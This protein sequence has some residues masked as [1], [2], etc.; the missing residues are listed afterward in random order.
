MWSDTAPVGRNVTRAWLCRGGGGAEIAEVGRPAVRDPRCGE[1]DEEHGL[2]RLRRVLE[3]HADL[4]ERAVAL[5]E[6]ARRTGGDDVLPDRLAALRARD[7]VVEGEPPARAAAVD[8]APAVA[9]EEGAAR[10][11][12][13]DRPWHADIVDQ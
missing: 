1:L 6:V 10:D 13:L 11:L 4:L 12:P 8:A 3:L 2:G 5:A 7:D 9:G